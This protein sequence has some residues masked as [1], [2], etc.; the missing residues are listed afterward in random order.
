MGV[1]HDM[2]V[3]VNRTSKPL[4]VMY[5]GQRTI[6]EPN[7]DEIGDPIEGVVNMLPRQVIPYA[8][9]QHVLLGSESFHNPSDF[10]SLIGVVDYKAKK[11]YSWHDCSFLEQSTEELT[12]V[13]Q[14]QIMDE[15]PLIKGFK[16]AGK[17]QLRPD[18]LGAQVPTVFDLKG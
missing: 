16:V 15:D 4:Q 17:K 11:K 14:E 3:V 2:V 18:D 7:Y 8:L 10:R 6:L 5:D 1:F 12:R 13:P 9:N